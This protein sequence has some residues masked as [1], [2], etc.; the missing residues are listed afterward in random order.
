MRW[1]SKVDLRVEE[2][3][4]PE[5]VWPSGTDPAAELLVSLQ[6]LTEP[7]AQRGRRPA[8]PQPQARNP[9]IKHAVESVAQILRHDDGACSVRQIMSYNNYN[10]NL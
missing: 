4:E 8:E 10:N 1:N 2:A 3:G 9:S 7:E 6:Q 5:L